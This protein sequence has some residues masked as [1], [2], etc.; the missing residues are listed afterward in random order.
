MVNYNSIICDEKWVYLFIAFF[1][2]PRNT[3][4]SITSTVLSTLPYYVYA[5]ACVYVLEINRRGE[6]T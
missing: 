1:L 2:T 4:I 3:K 6:N 5:R